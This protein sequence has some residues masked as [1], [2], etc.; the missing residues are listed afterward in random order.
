MISDH[1]I[2]LLRGAKAIAYLISGQPEKMLNLF[3]ETEIQKHIHHVGIQEVLDMKTDDAEAMKR[4]SNY[5]STNEAIE[6]VVTPSEAK[7][8]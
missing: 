4:G 3:Q 2:F 8:E 5:G 1:V 6:M 7:K